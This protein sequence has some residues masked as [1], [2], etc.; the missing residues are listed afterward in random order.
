MSWCLASREHPELRVER[1]FD[2]RQVSWVNLRYRPEGAFVRFDTR[3]SAEATLRALVQRVD[4]GPE[5]RPLAEC[6][7]VALEC[8]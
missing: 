1:I 6:D 7:V 8:S 5:L 3:D 2:D 4:G